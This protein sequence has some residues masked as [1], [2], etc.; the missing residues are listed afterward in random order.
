MYGS[1]NC[2]EFSLAGDCV[3]YHPIPAQIKHRFA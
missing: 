1:Y 2:V 3:E